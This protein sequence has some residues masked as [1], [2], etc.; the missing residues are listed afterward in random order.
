MNFI[1]KRLKFLTFLPI[2]TVLLMSGCASMYGL[3]EDP[4]ISI[5]DI[6]VQDV[7][8]LE[9]IFLIK[10]RVLNPN[11]VP[12]NLHGISCDL[13]INTRHFANGIGDNSQ[14]VPPFGTAIVPVEVYAS[15]L[16]MIAS[17]ADFLH[18]SGKTSVQDKPI[19]YILRGT[20]RI[21]V[22]GFSR[23]VPFK[24]S[25]E[26]SLQGLSLPR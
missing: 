12:L 1:W 24:S 13:E 11:E 5:A 23:E 7:K 26:V 16:D 25:G 15:V 8:A 20:I 4:K 21:G 18:S 6:R 17:V 10:L 3:K 22:H 9:G 19:P 2:C 14:T